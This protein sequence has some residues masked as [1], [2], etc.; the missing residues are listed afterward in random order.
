MKNSIVKENIIQ[1]THCIYKMALKCQKIVKEVAKNT[2]MVEP[3]STR[4]LL[5][6]S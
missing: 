1:L 2:S 6:H 3:P 5:S 4:M